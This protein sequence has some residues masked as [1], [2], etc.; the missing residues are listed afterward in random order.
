MKRGILLAVVM[1][2]IAFASG[3]QVSITSP[4]TGQNIS[5]ANSPFLINISIMNS[6]A[7]FLNVSS[8][9][10][11]FSGISACDNNSAFETTDQSYTCVWDAS[12]LNGTYTLN[13]SVYNL[14]VDGS[15]VINSTTF[16]VNVDTLLP[17]VTLISSDLNTSNNN[18]TLSYNATDYNLSSC[19]IYFGPSASWGI[20]AS[21]ASLYTKTVSAS[22]VNLSVPD[23]NYV[24]NVLCT[25]LLGNANFSQANVSITIDTVPPSYDTD[26]FA[27]EN[28]SNYTIS[29]ENTIHFVANWTDALLNVSMAW[30]DVNGTMISSALAID[31]NKVNISWA[32]NGSYV[33]VWNLTGYANDTVGNRN[34]TDS[35]IITITDGT[36]PSVI[37]DSPV[38][39]YNTSASAINFNFTV[40]DNF[41]ASLSCN[42]S[43]DGTVNVSDITAAS[44][45]YQVNT[46]TSLPDGIYSWNVSCDDAAGNRNA[47]LSRT[48][49]VDSVPPVTAPN[50]TAIFDTDSDGNI[51][52]AWT[53]DM[54]AMKYGVFRST[55]NFSDASSVTWLANVTGLSFEDNSSYMGIEY[56]YAITSIDFS[57]NENRSII[58][59]GTP[60]NA[61]ANDTITPASTMNVSVTTSSNTATIQWRLVSNDSLGNPDGTGM[62]YKVWYSTNTSLNTALNASA[63]GMTFYTAKNSTNFTTLDF[64][65]TAGYIFAVTTLDD[66]GNA[67]E[68]LSFS[69]LHNLT[70]TYVAPSEEDSS[71]SSSSGGGGGSTTPLNT[72]QLDANTFD[73]GAKTWATVS[74]ST[75]VTWNLS[76]DKIAIR[77]VTLTTSTTFT[78]VNLEISSKK[79]VSV[80]EP[81]KFVYQYLEIKSGLPE[82]GLSSATLRF[83]M[84]LSWFTTNKI[85]RD[86]VRLLRY[87]NGWME[88]STKEI[89][90]DSG[91][92]YYEATTPGFSFFAIVGIKPAAKSASVNETVQ[93][94]VPSGDAQKEESVEE[95]SV[96]EKPSL[97]W[98]WWTIAALAMV[99]IGVYLFITHQKGEEE[100]KG[101]KK[102]D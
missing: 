16:T 85:D 98:L 67:N 95:E 8:V 83:R 93:Q 27:L 100:K 97:S 56:W 42:I 73:K 40:T 41:D 90:S 24:Y 91:F 77:S 64:G 37:S 69:N 79:A 70:L 68:T 7:D 2:L 63:A 30:L 28:V 96:P 12:D 10:A 23:G 21:N 45:T 32:V 9:N 101:H 65:A 38:S 59:N 54:N 88:L 57:G 47:S 44:G 66:A 61:T 1:G 48:F 89:S 51:N 72:V 31:G 11:T 84:P 34:A 39:G 43:I 26:Y 18:I 92:A 4:M 36:L 46:S 76:R 55:S 60:F 13:I 58:S 80:S 50:L 33:G 15:E 86:S 14:T 87:S 99:G 22:A 52:L 94:E 75:P 29:T 20:L 74:G 5:R 17:E 102:K 62:S 71:S 82:S 25:D 53:A 19:D 35:I 49:S 3:L 78:N 81:P 6:T